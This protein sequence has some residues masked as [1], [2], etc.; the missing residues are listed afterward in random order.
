M[1]LQ[2]LIIFACLALGELI[3]YL[4]GISIPSC[5]IGMLLL[6]LFLELKWIKLEWVKGISNFLISNMGF[7]FIP[8]GIAL[9][10][11]FQ[12]LKDDWFSIITATLLSTILVLITTGHVHQVSRKL[13]KPKV[14]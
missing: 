4:T 8:P 7:F 1:I 13:V 10:Q 6:T 2:C 9:M 11:Y 12:L 5:I 14:K 3:V